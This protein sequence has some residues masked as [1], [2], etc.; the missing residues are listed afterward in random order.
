MDDSTKKPAS[1]K[2]GDGN[3]K[4]APS[5]NNMVWYLLG[6]GVLLLL[7]VMFIRSG[8]QMDI[9]WSDLEKLVAATD[10]DNLQDGGSYVMNDESDTQPRKWKL[11]LLKDI[12]VAEHEITG[13]VTRQ[14]IVEPNPKQTATGPATPPKGE[15]VS[16][17]TARDRN[18][19][20]IQK[21]LT[22][23]N[24]NYE[25]VRQQSQLI[26]YLMTLAFMGLM[27][28]LFVMMLRRMGGAGSPMAFG[29][30]RG[31]LIAQEDV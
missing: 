20:S 10:P 3:K 22:E 17:S 26:G 4:P 21:L 23:H 30:S 11:S 27:I 5:N 29:R 16:F 14:E 31:K 9:P 25:N 12:E 8:T 18:D 7:M 19:E 1:G 13:K 24:H 2:S 15:E 28:L 6:L